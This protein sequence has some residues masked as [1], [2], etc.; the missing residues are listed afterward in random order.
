MKIPSSPLAGTSFFGSWLDVWSR[1]C[2]GCYGMKGWPCRLCAL[3]ASFKMVL[4]KRSVV[5]EATP[6]PSTCVGALLRIQTF[7]GSPCAER[8]TA[9]TQRI[10]ATCYWSTAQYGLFDLLGISGVPGWNCHQD[11]FWTAI[12]KSAIQNHYRNVRRNQADFFPEHLTLRGFKAVGK[13]TTA[14][15]LL[16]LPAI[17]S[18][19]LWHWPRVAVYLDTLIY[20]VISLKS[21]S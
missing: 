4:Y 9:L 10:E 5:I 1:Q 17:H 8:S 12:Q 20:M 7:A 11:V 18:R 19:R 2:K 21:C 3:R 13:L 14:R 15:K 6:G 16:S